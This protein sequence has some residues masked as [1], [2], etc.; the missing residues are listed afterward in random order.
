MNHPSPIAAL[1]A[2]LATLA[3]LAALA[4]LAAPALAGDEL[5]MQDLQALAAQRGWTELLDRAD[6]VKPSARTADWT[7]LVTSAATHVVE[8]IDRGD[9]DL[10]AAEALVAAIPP[11]EARYGFLRADKAYLA[12]KAKAVARVARACSHGGRGCGA[13]IDALADGVDRFPRGVARQ[14]AVLVTDDTA[15][16]QAVRYWALAAED[17]ADA[18]KDGRLERAVLGAL[19]GAGGAQ[20]ADA[21]RAATTCYAALE[22]ALVGALDAARPSDPFIPHACPV[23]KAH[24]TKTVVK[25]KC[26]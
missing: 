20:L 26:P 13:L 21:Q 7:R 24:G 25:K 23:L 14:I 10:R 5:S 2:A 9:S 4:A 11:A 17:D 3:T 8:D 22:I 12:G 6:R 18:C 19:R 16:A 15:P 1:V